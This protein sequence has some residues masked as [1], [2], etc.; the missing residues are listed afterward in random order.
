MFIHLQQPIR[1]VPFRA[2]LLQSCER[3][4]G[5]RTFGSMMSINSKTV[6]KTK[7]HFTAWHCKY[8]NTIICESQ[9]SLL[10]YKKTKRWGSHVPYVLNQ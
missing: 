8:E 10:R 5:N 4:F 2:Q 9:I 1:E 3:D 6:L 7:I